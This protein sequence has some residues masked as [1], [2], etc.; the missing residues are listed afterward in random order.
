M[1]QTLE[2]SLGASRPDRRLAPPRFGVRRISELS[3]SAAAGDLRAATHGG[4]VAPPI[5]ACRSLAH[6]HPTE[7]FRRSGDAARG[8]RAALRA[9]NGPPGK[10]GLVIPNFPA[11]L[12]ANT[13]NRALPD[14]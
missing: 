3:L 12:A 1:S 11:N 7:T 4:A 9:P 10:L 5:R 8:T 2:D 13:P 14:A 6:H